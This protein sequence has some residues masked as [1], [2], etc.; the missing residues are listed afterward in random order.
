MIVTYMKKLLN[1]LVKILAYKE[2]EDA[3]EGK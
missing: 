3:V 2:V 1:I